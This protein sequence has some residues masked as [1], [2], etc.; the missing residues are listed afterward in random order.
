MPKTFRS[1]PLILILILISSG[2]FGCGYFAVMVR[3]AFSGGESLREL[4]RT[5]PGRC[6]V[7]YGRFYRPENDSGR[8]FAVVALVN[9][10][11]GVQIVDRTDA[12]RS[13]YYSLYLPEGR[14]QLAAF[15]D[16]NGDR[17][18]DSSE[19]VWMSPPERPLKVAQ[20]GQIINGPDMKDFSSVNCAVPVRFS[21]IASRGTAS[22]RYYPP[23][24]LRPLSDPI[25]DQEMAKTGLYDPSEFLKKANLY[26]YAPE[27]HIPG[28]TPVIFVHG[29]GGSPREFETIV[30]A[31]DPEKFE[32]WFF[33]YPSGE[34][35]D[36]M[37]SVFYE[38]FLSGR[39][40]DT[41]RNRPVICA[42]SM[43]GLVARAA[44]NQYRRE[45]NEGVLP[46]YISLCSPYGGNASAADGVKSA[47]VVLPAWEDVASGSVFVNSL[48]LDSLPDGM[49][50][51]LLFGYRNDGSFKTGDNS[52][53]VISL[54]SQLRA[55]AQE[56]AVLVK[57]YNETHTGILEASDVIAELMEAFEK[58]R[59]K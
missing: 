13:G 1:I 11:S 3:H 36:K 58:A 19:C 21:S 44:I 16:A 47:P 51:H 27:E 6:A 50:F 18:F 22:S 2:L 40:I 38:I 20:A 31:L 56:Q 37:A 54:S 8:A 53:G 24:C 48:F 10:R 35:L 42:H 49:E 43:G 52:D 12:D 59:G 45:R 9:D 46:L 32:P 41:R 15:A 4:R 5:A 14:Y 28:R 23:G 17:A 34:D 55:E 57:G 29:I 7:V 26:F 25:F 30:K 33:Y 39:V